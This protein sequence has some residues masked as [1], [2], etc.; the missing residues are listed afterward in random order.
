MS[1]MAGPLDDG[2]HRQSVATRRPWPMRNSLP[3]TPSRRP[4]PSIGIVNLALAK[5]AKSSASCDRR[6]GH[7]QSLPSCRRA[8]H[9]PPHR[10]GG[11]ARKRSARDRPRTRS[12]NARSRCARGRRRAPAASSHRNGNATCPRSSQTFFQSPTPG[13]NAFHQHDALH[14]R[15]ILGG[16]RI[17][18]HQPDIVAH[19]RE[20]ADARARRRA[21]WTSC[22]IV[23]LS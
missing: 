21:L 20:A 1:P 4:A 12:R 19:D 13:R 3:P 2:A 11:R 9:R 14:L 8:G 17:G 18:D 16:I 5:P 10:T 7:L 22:A 6:H 23:F 15:R